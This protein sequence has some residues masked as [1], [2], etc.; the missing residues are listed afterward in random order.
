MIKK[1]ESDAIPIENQLGLILSKEAKS[2]LASLSMPNIYGKKLY[3]IFSSN[4]TSTVVTDNIFEAPANGYI[5][6]IITS[7]G[8][9]AGY[10]YED[11][12]E[13]YLIDEFFRIG[14]FGTW[15]MTDRFMAPIQKG[16]KFYIRKEMAS[17]PNAVLHSSYFIYAK[18]E[19]E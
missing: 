16:Q 9:L 1:K 12:P 19:V 2:Y 11:N 13:V 3:N 15:S 5:C 8:I 17:N 7:G 4:I 10:Y 14:T 18:G 6:V